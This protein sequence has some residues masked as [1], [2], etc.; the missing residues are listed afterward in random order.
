VR[1]GKNTLPLSDVLDDSDAIDEAV[2]EVEFQSRLKKL[3]KLPS[4]KR[5]ELM[6]DMIVS[7]DKKEPSI[8]NPR[9]SGGVQAAHLAQFNRHVRQNNKLLES[10][11]LCLKCRQWVERKN[12]REE[13][14]IFYCG[15]CWEVCF[16]ERKSKWIPGRE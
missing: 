16:G 13:N 15:Y 11:A 7:L 10:D 9:E 3:S 1:E 5:R 12:G 6:R 4:W 2:D 14:G 8:G